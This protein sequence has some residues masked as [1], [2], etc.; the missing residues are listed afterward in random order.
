MRGGCFFFND[1]VG[2]GTVRTKSSK[3]LGVTP[4][5]AAGFRNVQ[6]L[7]QDGSMWVERGEES[8]TG[9]TGTGGTRDLR[10]FEL[11]SHAGK[12]RANGFQRQK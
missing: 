8:I 12:T 5:R 9:I 1:E 10:P 4:W 2:K 11:E 6:K 7:K 3:I